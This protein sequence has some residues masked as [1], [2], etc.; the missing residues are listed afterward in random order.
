TSDISF[1]HWL[2]SGKLIKNVLKCR[3]KSC[4]YTPDAQRRQGIL[5]TNP[6]FK[7]VAVEMDAQRRQGIPRTNP[8]LKLH[9]PG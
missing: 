3:T 8:N 4:I 1:C 9:L 2:C 7:A 5:R 6:E